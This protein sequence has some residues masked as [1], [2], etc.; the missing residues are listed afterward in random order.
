LFLID[1]LFNS[2]RIR[3]SWRQKQ[4]ILEFAELLGGQNLPSHYAASKYQNLPSHY[5]ASKYQKLL[6]ERIE[7]STQK[8]VSGSGNIFYLNEI[9][10][11]LA[12]DISNPISRPGMSFYPHYEGNEMS[13]TWNE[14]KMLCDTPDHLLT[15]TLCYNNHLY[16]VNEVVQRMNGDY[17]LPN[18]WVLCGKDKVSGCLGYVVQIEMVSFW[19]LCVVYCRVSC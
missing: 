3:F 10:A 18:R 17:F 15:P 8:F 12:R 1:I 5:A 11:S 19:P 9:G 6:R 2:P 13:Q 7:P 16:Y 4:A 14:S